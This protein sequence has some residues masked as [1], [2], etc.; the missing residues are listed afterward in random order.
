MSAN[1]RPK[2]LLLRVWEESDSDGS[3]EWCG[4][5]QLVAGGKAHNFRNWSGLVSAVQDICS[6]TSDPQLSTQAQVDS[7]HTIE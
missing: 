2:F 5:V 4:R 7:G 1:S 6:P 3:T